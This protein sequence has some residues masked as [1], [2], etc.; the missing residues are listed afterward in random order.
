MACLVTPAAVAV[1]TTLFK[2]RIPDKYHINWLNQMLWGGTAM[3][4]VDHV[5]SGEIVFSF[6]F[7]TRSFSEIWHEIG[8]VGLLMTGAVVVVWLFA[9]LIVNL[10]FQN[11][12]A[13]I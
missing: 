13:K 7:F 2:N 12:T 10:R 4:L 3:L 1:V 9:I 11:N 5:L 6:P 8:S